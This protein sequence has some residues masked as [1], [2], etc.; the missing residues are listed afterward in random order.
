MLAFKEDSAPC[1]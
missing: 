1:S